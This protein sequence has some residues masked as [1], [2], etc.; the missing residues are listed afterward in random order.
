V[1]PL[2][3]SVTIVPFVWSVIG[4]S[5]AFALGM[6]IDL[7]LVTAGGALGAYMW[8][9]RALS[10]PEVHHDDHLNVDRSAREAAGLEPPLA[11]GNDRL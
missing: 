3:L 5:A 11:R 7:A 10:D 4:G 6:P 1:R 9:S 8:L 2:P